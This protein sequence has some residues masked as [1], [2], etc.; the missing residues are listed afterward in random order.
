MLLDRFLKYIG[1]H[2]LIGRDER[3]LLAVSGGVDSMAMLHLFRDGGYN[4]GVAHCNFGLR[5]DESD[6]DEKSVAEECAKLGVPHYNIRFDTASQ[7][8]SSGESVQMVARRLRYDWFDELST[9]HGYT[10]IAIAHHID[11]SIETFFIN[12]IRGTGLR[13]LTGINAINGKLVRPLLF[14]TRREIL[15]YAAANKVPYRE[16]SSNSSTKYLR[17]KIRLGII[18]MI[19]EISPSFGRTMVRNVE[20]LSFALDFVDR[21]TE[22]IRGEVT[23]WEGN[24]DVIDIDRINPAL[25]RRYV[26]Y[27]LLRPYG[28]NTDVVADL[29][30]SYLAGR[31]GTSFSTI[32]HIAYLDRGRIIIN[33]MCE[34]KEFEAK[35]EQ[36]CADESCVRGL[37]RFETV[38]IE[39][40]ES[41]KQPQNVALLDAS[42]VHWPLTV[43]KWND[44]DSFIPFGMDG[45][46][47]VSDF[48]ID[49]K[50]SMPDKQRQ[51]VVVSGDDIVWLVDRRIDDRYKVTSSTK[52]VLRITRQQS[53]DSVLV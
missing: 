11:D 17:N 10:K 36:E 15:D 23:T 29:Y 22:I 39:D 42:L 38:E 46:K 9:E 8:R 5:G 47:K 24:S 31:S 50:I 20:R 51:L 18:P 33:R 34:T 53:D 28:F 3:V 44:G 1:E 6:E 16:D 27:E 43:R 26:I 45:R 2:D 30:H 37:L 14:A 40:M 7:V 13:G 48:L 41:L 25:P 12:L 21:Q 49:E 19:R 52:L 4:I 32:S 35:I